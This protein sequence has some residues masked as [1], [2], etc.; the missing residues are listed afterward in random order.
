MG[1]LAERVQEQAARIR[2]QAQAQVQVQESGSEPGPELMLAPELNGLTEGQVSA[3]GEQAVL[4]VVGG[5]RVLHLEAEGSSTGRAK[6]PN[7]R[8][9]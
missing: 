4:R 7:T 2:M 9:E 5:S 3:L 6:E 1:W 8:L